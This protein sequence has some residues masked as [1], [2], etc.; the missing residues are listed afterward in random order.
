[1]GDGWAQVEEAFSEILCQSQKEQT[2]CTCGT[3]NRAFKIEC[4]KKARNNEHY[5]TLVY[6]SHY[7][8]VEHHIYLIGHM[9]IRTSI[10]H[11]RMIAYESKGKGSGKSNKCMHA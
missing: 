5:G 7:M 11:I 6:V 4:I 2:K 3:V 9:L 8:H 10:G 1:M